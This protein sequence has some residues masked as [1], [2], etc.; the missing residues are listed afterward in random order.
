[1]KKYHLLAVLALLAFGYAEPREPN[2]VFILVDDLGYMDIGANNP[3]TFY[4]TPSI[5]KLASEGIRLTQ[6]YAAA[7]VCSPTRA[8]I[9]TGQYPGRLQ[10]TD[11]FGAVQ[12]DKVGPNYA[13]S[14]K[15]LPAPYVDQL[16]SS[17]LTMAE[18]LKKKGYATFF[19]GKWHLGNEGF[20]P[21]D[22]GFEV[23]RGGHEAGGPYGGSRYFSPYGNPKLDDGP[24]GELLPTRLGRETAD[25][26]RNNSNKP[27]LAFLS[28]YSVHTP[29]MTTPE[30]QSKYE[31]KKLALGSQT[32]WGEE[33][34]RKVRQSQDHAI[35][36]G[37]IESMDAA[38]GEVMAAIED[39]GVADRTIIIFTSDNGGL[40]T[41]E[42]H[43]TSN[44]PYRAGKG[45]LY[46]GGILEP[47]IIK[48]P[49]ETMP[50]SVSA[51][52]VS[53]IDYLP[54]MLEIA[55]LESKITDG[56]SIVPVLRGKN[57]PERTLFWHYPHYG[58]QGGSPSGA[59]RKGPWKLIQFF[60]ND[61]AELYNL[62]EDP[63]ETR[64]LA[65]VRSEL[66]TAMLAELKRWQREAG[67]LF[68]TPV[69][70]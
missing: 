63:S 61:E 6:A 41:S 8:S 67:V 47:T 17:E 4:E 5:D 14:R 13:D 66:T 46:E 58:N 44:I 68:P 64:D 32:V 42:G 45:W 22:H 1:M 59:I 20:Y 19:A 69:Q 40:S 23:N 33:G 27:F 12:P 38:V 9:M 3:Q 52:L 30:L 37:M 11:Y 43:P 57:Q 18:A 51:E 28:F 29:L 16:P 21:E 49:G 56:R 31:A 48:W 62:D 39:A 25:F 2:F 24:D 60:E 35:Y 15:M 36:A 26:I 55:G 10:T 54:T 70:K 7:P 34:L 53:S 50:G 65:M